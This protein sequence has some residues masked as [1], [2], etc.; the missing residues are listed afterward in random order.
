MSFLWCGVYFAGSQ[1]AKQNKMRAMRAALLIAAIANVG[2]GI[3]LPVLER[4][5]LMPL[6]LRGGASAFAPMH[7]VFKQRPAV[8]KTEVENVAEADAKPNLRREES[9][10]V[11]SEVIGHHAGSLF[12]RGR[13]SEDTCVLSRMDQSR[14]FLLLP[15]L[16]FT[17]LAA[18][19]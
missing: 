7:G 9:R 13:R 2:G 11:L 10:L 6:R 17:L 5:A 1:Q 12:L 3:V 18:L 16:L 4:S 15:M 14:S 19:I 8:V